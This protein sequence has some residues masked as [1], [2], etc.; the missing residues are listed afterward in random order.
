MSEQK[1]TQFVATIPGEY[2]KN[3]ESRLKEAFSAI[4]KLA[5]PEAVTYVKYLTSPET[6]D[7]EEHWEILEQS[8]SDLLLKRTDL[9]ST[10]ISRKM[11]VGLSRAGVTTLGQV[12]A[13]SGEQIMLLP[14]F[15]HQAATSRRALTRLLSATR[16]ESNGK[17]PPQLVQPGPSDIS[18]VCRKLGDVPALALGQGDTLDQYIIGKF[19]SVEELTILSSSEISSRLDSYGYDE[20]V[21]NY[22]DEL[23]RSA[24][25]FADDFL[26]GKTAER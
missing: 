9:I 22:A 8:I 7:N 3:E 4:G 25:A 10:R 12:L 26:S 5:T 17:I 11:G 6:S 15:G 20:V 24:V 14:H 23:K 19:T 16:I 21:Q 2:S 1:Y 18:M 13:L